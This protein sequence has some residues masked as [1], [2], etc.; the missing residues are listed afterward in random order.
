MH[1]DKAI[2]AFLLHG[3]PS[4]TDIRRVL[5]CLSCQYDKE[6]CRKGWCAETF[7]RV[8]YRE[9][10]KWDPCPSWLSVSPQTACVTR[11]VHYDPYWSE[12]ESESYIYGLVE[13]KHGKLWI[14]ETEVAVDDST[15]PMYE[16]DVQATTVLDVHKKYGW[17]GLAVL[18][19]KF[20]FMAIHKLV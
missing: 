17:A 8:F 16:D 10:P 6:L 12:D 5:G 11:R 18:L 7:R 15:Q 19:D 1:T 3:D 20:G 13:L 4:A 14:T 2:C 9:I